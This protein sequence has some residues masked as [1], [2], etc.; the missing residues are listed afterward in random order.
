MERVGRRVAWPHSARG[1]ERQRVR[2][3]NKEAKMKENDDK[4]W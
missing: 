3:R 2:R 4:G 1:N